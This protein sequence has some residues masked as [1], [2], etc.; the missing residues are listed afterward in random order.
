[1]TPAPFQKF[2]NSWMVHYCFFIK[3]HYFSV[4]KYIKIYSAGKSAG[5]RSLNS[6]AGVGRQVETVTPNGEWPQGSG[7]GMGK[8]KGSLGERGAIRSAKTW[9]PGLAYLIGA[10]P[11]LGFPLGGRGLRQGVPLVFSGTLLGTNHGLGEVGALGNSSG[12]AYSWVPY[13]TS[14]TGQSSIIAALVWIF[15]ALFPGALMLLGEGG[16]DGTDAGIFPWGRQTG[17]GETS[18]D[19]QGR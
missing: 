19:D 10:R 1:M 15:L 13:R 17:G 5:G 18:S 2:I 9:G 6:L 8:W 12:L 16:G 7:G 11:L 3:R 14:P 4:S